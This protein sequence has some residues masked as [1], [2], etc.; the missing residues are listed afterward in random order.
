[1]FSVIIFTGMLYVV[2]LGGSG[3]G[4]SPTVAARDGVF[5]ASANVPKWTLTEVE[6]LNVGML[7]GTERN[8]VIV[9][10]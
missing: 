3:S 10:L 6:V 1:M 8:R 9:A 7:C 2:S 5:L 4:S